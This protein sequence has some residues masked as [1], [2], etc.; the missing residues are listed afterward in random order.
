MAMYGKN[1]SNDN[2][3]EA[4]FLFTQHKYYYLEISFCVNSFATKTFL[5]EYVI[6]IFTVPT[7]NL[8]TMT[9]FPFK[10][11]KL[12]LLKMSISLL[13]PWKNKLIYDEDKH[14]K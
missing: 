13:C 11:Y 8:W 1:D 10:S 4:I 6:L 9:C 14:S 5:F 12:F 2:V 3:I 7:P